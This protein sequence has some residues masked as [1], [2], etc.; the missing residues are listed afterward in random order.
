MSATPLGQSAEIVYQR[1]AIVDAMVRKKGWNVGVCN[2]LALTLGVDRRTVYRLRAMANR[3]TRTHVRPT[4]IE[5]FRLQ[6]LVAL[7]DISNEAREAKDYS[8]AVRAIDTQAKIIG[9]IAPTKVDVNHSVTV[10]PALVAQMSRLSVDELRTLTDAKNEN[11]APIIEAEFE[12]VAEVEP[13][14]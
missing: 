14:K 7:S 8:A 4:D 13:A 3:W 5:A 6:Q 9:T 11:A 10:N 2:E 12:P 1:V